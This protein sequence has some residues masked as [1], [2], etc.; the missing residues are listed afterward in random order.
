MSDT[1]KD[2]EP[3]S[4]LATFHYD[5]EGQLLSVDAPTPPDVTWE[6]DEARRVFRITSETGQVTEF[7]DRAAR[8]LVV[9]PDPETGKLRPVIS[10]G[11]PRVMYLCREA[12]L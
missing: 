12:G 5:P 7:H 11:V 8:F 2:H 1:G 9:V 6:H 10:W 4:F 3:D